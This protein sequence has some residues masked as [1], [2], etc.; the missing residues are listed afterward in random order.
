MTRR[1]LASPSLKLLIVQRM[2]SSRRSLPLLSLFCYPRN[3]SH[4]SVYLPCPLLV[5]LTFL[6]SLP[7]TY[8]FFVTQER[9]LVLNVNNYVTYDVQIWAVWLSQARRHSRSSIIFSSD[10]SKRRKSHCGRR[11]CIFLL[12]R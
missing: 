12:I 4:L 3:F 10:H 7:P 1:V 11:R 5:P 2:S 6:L 9:N 8:F